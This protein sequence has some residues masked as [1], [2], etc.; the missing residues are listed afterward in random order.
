MVEDQAQTSMH[1]VVVDEAANK[2]GQPILG[3]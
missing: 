1:P 2:I 3:S